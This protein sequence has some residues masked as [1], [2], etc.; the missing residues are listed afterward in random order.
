MNDLAILRLA[1]GVARHAAERHA[2]VTR[3]IANAD[4]VGYRAR[5][6]A[7]FETVLAEDGTLRATRAGHL[8]GGDA[9]R[10]RP[11]HDAAAG[12]M[13]PNGNDVALDQQLAKAAN[14]MG[15]HG[16]AV[17]VYGKTLD[18]LRLAIRGR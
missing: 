13:S 2:L 17:A 3:N 4:T 5:D 8:V 7:P 12:A 9:L 18:I 10:F 6:L 1:D 15:A 16:K 11:I 14:A